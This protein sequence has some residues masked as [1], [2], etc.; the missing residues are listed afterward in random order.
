MEIYGILFT[1]VFFWVDNLLIYRRFSLQVSPRQFE[2][3]MAGRVQKGPGCFS[4]AIGQICRKSLIRGIRKN[5][6]PLVN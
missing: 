1:D 2:G 4:A 3:L 6:Y 5:G